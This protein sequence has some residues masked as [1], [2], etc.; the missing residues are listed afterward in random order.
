MLRCGRDLGA[1]ALQGQGVLAPQG[2]EQL[3]HFSLAGQDARRRLRTLIRPSRLGLVPMRTGPF[4]DAPGQR[5]HGGELRLYFLEQLH[6]ALYH[7]ADQVL[8]ILG[9]QDFA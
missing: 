7:L 6:D 5:C 8:I 2:R 1:A 3:V 9:D 4:C